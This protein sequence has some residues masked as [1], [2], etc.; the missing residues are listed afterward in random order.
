MTLDEKRRKSIRA[1]ELAVDIPAF[2]GLDPGSSELRRP[3]AAFGTCAPS[4]TTLR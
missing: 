3:P 4:A 2:L 1:F